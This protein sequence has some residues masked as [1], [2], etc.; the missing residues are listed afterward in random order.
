M[1]WLFSPG[2]TTFIEVLP[3]EALQMGVALELSSITRAAFSILV[4]ELAF[5]EAATGQAP[6]KAAALTVFGRR[7]QDPGDDLSNIIQH[8]ARALVARTALSVKQLSSSDLLAML[9]LPEWQKLKALKALLEEER[10]T[11]PIF[12]NARIQL[13]RV[14]DA[15][16]HNIK[17]GFEQSVKAVIPHERA[18]AI[19]DYRTTYVDIKDFVGFDTI[20]H[21]FNAVQRCLCA[22]VFGEMNYNFVHRFSFFTISQHHNTA[23]LPISRLV[24]AVNKAMATVFKVDPSLRWNPIWHTGCFS[25]EVFDQGKLQEEL[26]NALVPTLEARQLEDSELCLTMTSHLRLALQQNEMKYLPLWAGGTNDGTGGVFEEPLPPAT[27]GPIGPGPSY[28]TGFTLPSDQ[29]DASSVAGSIIREIRELK[30]SRGSTVGPGSVDVQD[31]ISTVYNPNYM[32]VEERSI[33][34]ESFTEGESEYGGARYQVPADHQ[35][36]SQAMDMLVDV[37]GDLED[38]NTDSDGRSITIA[39]VESVDTATM[40]EGD[41]SDSDMVLV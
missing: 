39:D 30:M 29:S 12:N 41:E 22:F 27:L 7:R 25:D 21:G 8:A 36:I 6:L 38:P 17:G 26:V 2:N 16:S 13:T 31:S 37:A 3:E 18:S 28:N 23:G 35:S 34:S 9:E 14:M 40:T 4:N 5:E 1:S 24:E 20:Y 15:F 32:I 33:A 19:D 11:H 10:D